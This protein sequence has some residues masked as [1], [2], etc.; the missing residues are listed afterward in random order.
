MLMDFLNTRD[1]RTFSVHGQ[2]HTGGDDLG[3]PTAA[4]RWLRGQGLLSRRAQL[5]ARDVDELLL[6]RR[7]LR[8]ALEVRAGHAGTK[9]L[10]GVNT[11]LAGLP[12]TVRLDGNGEPHLAAAT[13]GVLGTLSELLA[14]V[15]ANQQW[16]RLRMCAAPDCRWV[17]YDT[18]RNGAGRWCS[19]AVCGN[20][21]KTRR[22]RER[23]TSA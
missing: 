19:M 8:D 4:T 14:R 5:P 7:A 1:D 12:V 13:T 16:Y 11:R 3:S 9:A 15:V 23:R 22:Y 20:R 21:E 2:T 17:F 6:L 18:S 10:A